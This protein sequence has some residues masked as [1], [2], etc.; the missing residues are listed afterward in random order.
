MLS[1]MIEVSK[2]LAAAF[3]ARQAMFCEQNDTTPS[4]LPGRNAVHN[5]T[6]KILRVSVLWAAIWSPGSINCRA[7][8]SEPATVGYLV[9]EG[10][11]R[12]RRGDHR[13]AIEQYDRAIKSD[14]ASIEA[15]VYRLLPHSHR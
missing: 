13:A 15:Y 6:G 14:A 7:V 5:L 12:A 8:A 10:R 2:T 9:I 1:C 4:M 3:S 11:E